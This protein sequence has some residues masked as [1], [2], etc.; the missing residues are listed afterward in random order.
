[1]A[2]SAT[3][4]DGERYALVNTDADADVNDVIG[5]LDVANIA[6][7]EIGDDDNG[8][9]SSSQHSGNV[10]N[11]SDRASLERD[12][13]FALPEAETHSNGSANHGQRHDQSYQT[14]G[15]RKASDEGKDSV[16]NPGQKK[17]PIKFLKKLVSKDKDKKRA[18]AVEKLAK[19]DAM[20]KDIKVDKLPQVFVT[21]YMGYKA[22]DGL[23]GIRSTR[24]PV[25]ELIAEVRDLP[26]GEDLPLTQLRIS[27]KGIDIREH[28]ASKCASKKIQKELVPIEFISYGVQ[29]IRYT[30]VFSFILVREMSS[31]SKKTECHAYVCDSTVTARKLALSLSLAFKEYAKTLDG[32][33]YRFQVDLRSAQELEEDLQTTDRDADVEV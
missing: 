25:E 5:K 10:S 30:R 11:A 12:S 31:R 8:S 6:K 1:M 15:Q 26:E 23:W 16:K 4:P 27:T 24:G 33:S 28:S 3:D 7:D 20:L 19:M 9:D 18:K 22:T 2:T 14:G 13:D 17:N 21:K 29:D 32:N